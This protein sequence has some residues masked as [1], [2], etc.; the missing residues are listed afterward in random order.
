MSFD[1][2]K[3]SGSVAKALVAAGC[4][5]TPDKIRAFRRALAGEED[6]N[7]R[8]VLEQLIAN[9]EAAESNRSPLCD[10]TG[11]PHLFIELGDNYALSADLIDAIE[12]GVELGLRELPGRPMAVKGDGE[13]RLA[14]AEGMFDDPG[15]VAPAPLAIKRVKG[16]VFKLSV[17]LFGGGPAIRGR[18]YRVFHR[19]DADVF[20][21]E[22]VKWAIQAC[23][24]LGCTPATLSIGIGRSHYE[25]AHLMLEAQVFGNY[26][27]QDALER[28]ITRAV[29]D[30]GSGVMGLG[31]NTTVL[32]TFM[33]IGPA[34]ASGVRIVCLRP[35]CCFEP[36]IARL[37]LRGY[38]G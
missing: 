20:K 29:N 22:I 32:A 8:W 38:H 7:A 1:E 14:Q 17:L 12:Y 31:G 34:R 15:L 36:R 18:S 26:D 16:D 24:E 2:E 35:S 10:D 9:G 5:Y 4:A 28:A 30:A 23:A 13:V 37:D 33:R 11:I 27:E 6:P 21:A 3:L 19:H 25:A